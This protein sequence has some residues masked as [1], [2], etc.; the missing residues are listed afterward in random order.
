MST[1]R[2]AP[3]HAGFSPPYRP[4]DPLRLIGSH[5]PGENRP[6]L[7]PK[8]PLGF[9]LMA[10]GF[11]KQFGWMRQANSGS[12]GAKQTAKMTKK[13]PPARKQA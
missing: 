13:T 7:N 1:G 3:P 6:G 4:G 8:F 5:P 2:A 9:A 11:L 10:D 12:I